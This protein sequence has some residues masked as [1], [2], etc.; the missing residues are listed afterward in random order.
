MR[1]LTLLFQTRCFP[2]H[3][4]HPQTQRAATTGDSHTVPGTHI[5][6]R[7]DVR[8]PRQLCIAVADV[9]SP[10]QMCNVC[11]AHQYRRAV[12]DTHMCGDGHTRATPRPFSSTDQQEHTQHPH[13]GAAPATLRTRARTAPRLRAYTHTG[14]VASAPLINERR[15]HAPQCPPNP[16]RRARGEAWPT[17]EECPMGR[18]GPAGAC[19]GRGHPKVWSRR[20]GPAAP[21]AAAARRRTGRDGPGL[22]GGLGGAGGRQRADLRGTAPAGSGPA[23][24]RRRTEPARPRLAL[25][26][27][28]RV[29]RTLRAGRAMGPLQVPGSAGVR[30]TV[31]TLRTGH[32]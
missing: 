21:P 22:A 20:R 27:P 29:F 8:S 14:G 10:A 9:Q 31:H 16:R 12:P 23:T 17:R 2:G 18:R 19:G 7:T 30:G 26:E 25:E 13:A 3:I 6:R 1:L 28:P 24:A 11:H 32:S 5:R 15:G 4:P